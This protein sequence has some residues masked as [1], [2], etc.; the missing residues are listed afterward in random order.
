MQS[1]SDGVKQSVA[2]ASFAGEAFTAINRA[3]G[4]VDELTE[5]IAQSAQEQNHTLTDIE[6]K[7]RNL[8]EVHANTVEVSQMTSQSGRQFMEISQRLDTLVQRFRS[9]RK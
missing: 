1:G 8:S 5:R 9:T 6:S 3:V 7:V 2:T 4:Q